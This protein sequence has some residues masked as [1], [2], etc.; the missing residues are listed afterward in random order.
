MHIFTGVIL[1]PSPS[2]K[3]IQSKLHRHYCI[4]NIVAVIYLAEDLYVCDLLKVI[5]LKLQRYLIA[6]FGLC[7]CAD[8]PMLG[9]VEGVEA[10]NLSDYDL[11]G[12][13]SGIR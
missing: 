6:M 10:W 8:C 7:L 11:V 4:V 3:S 2:L 9:S 5:L 13:L 1:Y 12:Q